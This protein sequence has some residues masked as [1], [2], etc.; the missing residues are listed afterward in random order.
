MKVPH[1]P[2]EFWKEEVVFQLQGCESENEVHMLVSDIRKKALESVT[3]MVND[4]ITDTVNEFL[5][6]DFYT[7]FRAGF[8]SATYKRFDLAAAKAYA[9]DIYKLYGYDEDVW[10][11]SI[12]GDTVYE[13]HGVVSDVESTDTED[14][15]EI[16]VEV[17][18]LT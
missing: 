1:N 7:V 16:V 18:D 6:D 5:G 9:D 13:L 4:A 15:E 10:I 11:D 3:V 12:Y 8:T 14:D 2:I 17:D